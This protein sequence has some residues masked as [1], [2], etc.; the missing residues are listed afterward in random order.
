MDPE[1]QK[2]FAQFIQAIA[3]GVAESLRQ[4]P[5]PQPPSPPPQYKP[6]EVIR[7]KPDGVKYR[8]QT[9]VPQ[10]LAEM[11]DRMEMIQEIAMDFDD[12]QFIPATKKRN[13][14]G[15]RG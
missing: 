4:H 11:C 6:V 14:R 10:L 3:E 7:V 2:Q 13:A 5:P 9:S 12:D 8:E 15:R 1:K